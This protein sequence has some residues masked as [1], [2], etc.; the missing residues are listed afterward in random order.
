MNK[1]KS[2]KL[3]S[4]LNNKILGSSELVQLLNDYLL[5]MRN[6]KIEF[7]SSIR[8]AKAKLGHFEAINSYL[9]EINSILKD[10]NKGE[11]KD[12]LMSHSST[13]NEKIETIFNKIYPKLKKIKRVIT[14]SRSRTVLEILKLWHRRNKNIKIV[15][16]ESRPKFEGR[17][18]AKEIAGNG[19]SV[20]L[21]TDAVMSLIVP[22][23][24]VAI[25]GADI[26]LKNGNVIN[27]VGSK[28]L[29]LLCKEYKKPFYVVTSHSK[30]SK[31]KI[32]KPKKENPQ[33]I[34]DRR[35]KNLSMSNIYFEE[36]E[37][38][39]ITKVFT[40]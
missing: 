36:I 9:K 40:D 5:S 10:E 2:L 33:E 15:I 27:K 22:K 30:L 21:I 25:I 31:K 1:S 11:L 29:A 14:L 4:I 19:I 24:D 38:K 7:I 16:C 8:L 6:N 39:F 20:E 32:F 26:V 18:M 17:S 3:K 34:W 12:F 28:V 23:V 35:V 37:K 13:E